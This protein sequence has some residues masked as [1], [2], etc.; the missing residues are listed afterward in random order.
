MKNLKYRRIYMNKKVGTIIMLLFFLQF[1]GCSGN[2][3]KL[4]KEEKLYVKIAKAAVFKEYGNETR[5][6]MLNGTVYDEQQV[7]TV[8]VEMK[9]DKKFTGVEGYLVAI[10]RQNK[11][12]AD[13][14]KVSC[15]PTNNQ[16]GRFITKN[17]NMNSGD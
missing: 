10:N 6:K 9:P 13:I 3:D 4:T 8:Y 12:V 5:S 16:I 14:Q 2:E 15:P 1:F 17:N 7:V 11:K